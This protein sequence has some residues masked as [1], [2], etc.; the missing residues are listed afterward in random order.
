[1]SP[2]VEQGTDTHPVSQQG[3]TMHPAVKQAL[4]RAQNNN[5]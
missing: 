2:V 1:M 3:A 4:S 5:R